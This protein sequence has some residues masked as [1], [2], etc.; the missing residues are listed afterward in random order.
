N[1]IYE[2][3]TVPIKFHELLQ[4]TNVGIPYSIIN[5]KNVTMESEK[6]VV[7]RDKDSSQIIIIDIS[8]STTQKRLPISAD[9]AIM[10]PLKKILATKNDKT[11]VIFDLDKPSKLKEHVHHEDVVYWRWIDKDTIGIVTETAVY[12]WNLAGDSGPMKMFDR[13]PTMSGC[14][15]I[16]YRT[17]SQLEWLIVIGISAKSKH[18]A[19]SMQLY[20]TDR[21][22]S[23]PIEGH[24]ACIVNYK[25]DGNTHPSTLFVFALKNEQGGRLNMVELVPLPTGNRAYPKKSVLV[26]Y[27]EEL[28]ADFPISL[29]A[30][31]EQGVV[32]LVTKDGLVHIF[33]LESGKIIYSNR[34]SE[35]T[36]FIT[37]DYSQGGVIGINRKGNVLSVSV[38]KQKM[39]DYVRETDPDLAHKL[40]RRW[41]PSF[42]AR[43]SLLA[44]ST[45]VAMWND[46]GRSES[47]ESPAPYS[48]VF[49]PPSQLLY[50]PLGSLSIKTQDSPLDISSIRLQDSPSG[51]S[52]V[53]RTLDSPPSRLFS[54]N[55][56][57]V[58]TYDTPNYEAL[59]FDMNA[60]TEKEVTEQDIFARYGVSR[61]TG[62]DPFDTREE[63]TK[64]REALL[65][66]ANDR[67]ER[68]E[69]ERDEIAARLREMT[70]I[71]NDSATR[72]ERAER[73]RDDIAARYWALKKKCR[74]AMN[75][76]QRA[77]TDDLSG[78]TRIM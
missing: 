46:D 66:M 17:D 12:H 45:S 6:F 18:V 37:T 71:H 38:D 19:G 16:N 77:D 44:L 65:E 27:S 2:K 11:L 7:C 30:S 34:I 31:S 52:S 22:I 41:N 13:H 32:Y 63:E 24:A 47:V 70:T 64:Y 21:Q 57:D 10:H 69:R 28:A 9:S 50:S 58:P 67:A 48:S 56:Q 15:I 20:S 4:L 60:N 42:T 23:Q 35:E 68:A 59:R 14:Q 43:D 78:E 33:D 25:M 75:I 72:I 76:L 39:V 8:D 40:S 3:M 29:Q 55:T 74:E 53:S 61:T 1:S 54:L 62:E 49:P 51:I 73:E 5:F 26:P 36:I